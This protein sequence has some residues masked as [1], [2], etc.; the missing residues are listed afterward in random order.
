MTQT[1][2]APVAQVAG[3]DIVNVGTPGGPPLTERSTEWLE[4]RR[5]HCRRKLSAAQRVLL[6]DVALPLVV[7]GF[8]GTGVL[9]YLFL[10]HKLSSGAIWLLPTWMAVSV[11]WPMYR[12]DVRRRREASYIRHYRR[13]LDAIEIVLYDRT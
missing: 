6:R 3:R 13:E 12:I 9:L 8:A 5:E 11:G 10:A 1:F 4:A 2:R 7:A